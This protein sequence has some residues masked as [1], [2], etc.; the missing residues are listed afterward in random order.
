MVGEVRE[1]RLKELGGLEQIVGVVERFSGPT[2]RLLGKRS[3]RVVRHRVPP[4]A[5]G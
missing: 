5:G 4:G 2:L 1:W 3:R